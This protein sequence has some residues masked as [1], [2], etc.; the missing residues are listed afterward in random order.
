MPETTRL[1]GVRI[2][3]P[4]SFQIEEAAPRSRIRGARPLPR[5]PVPRDSGATADDNDALLR[6]L[7]QQGL[8]L[9]DAVA[10]QP[11]LEPTMSSGQ[12]R[13]GAPYEN[14]A[15]EQEAD[16]RGHVFGTRMMLGH[17]S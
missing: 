14:V 17:A 16:F 5:G 6:A 2:G 15:F 4:D 10:L 7:E 12:R 8:Q 1:S 11:S 13:A 9:I 3:I